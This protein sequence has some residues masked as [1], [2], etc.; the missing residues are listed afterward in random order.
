M[1]EF[2]AFLLLLV[3]NLWNRIKKEGASA[4]LDAA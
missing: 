2:G 3:G 4:Q 1:Y